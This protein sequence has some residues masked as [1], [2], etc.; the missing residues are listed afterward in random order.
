M[1]LKFRDFDESP[2]FKVLKF[3][4]SKNNGARFLNCHFCVL[5]NLF[6]HNGIETQQAPAVAEM[7]NNVSNN[8]FEKYSGIS[9]RLSTGKKLN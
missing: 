9:N 5:D 8:I 3:R 4:E 2:F 1:G 7:F 6:N